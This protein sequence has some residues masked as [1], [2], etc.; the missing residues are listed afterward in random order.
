MP[1]NHRVRTVIDLPAP[2]LEPMTKGIAGSSQLIV[3]VLEVRSRLVRRQVYRPIKMHLH[4]GRL[5]TPIEI[6]YWLRHG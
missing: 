3:D 4:L 6:V 5:E 1:S 2:E